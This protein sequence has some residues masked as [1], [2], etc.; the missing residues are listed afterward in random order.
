MSKKKAPPSELVKTLLEVVGRIRTDAGR[1]AE[2]PPAAVDNPGTAEA[3]L[4]MFPAVATSVRTLRGV[5]FNEVPATRFVVH[6]ASRLGLTIS[7]RTF[8]QS[9]WRFVDLLLAIDPESDE[10]IL[11]A[12]RSAADLVHCCD[13]LIDDLD[14]PVMLPQDFKFLRLAIEAGAVNGV[15]K[16][17]TKFWDF[18]QSATAADPRKIRERLKKLNYLQTGAYIGVSVTPLGLHAFERRKQQGAH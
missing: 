18:K 5:G 12:A 9:R 4:E 17:T 1:F 15:A 6:N 14:P 7:A 13:T 2:R 8:A 3:V 10:S 11:K 16:E